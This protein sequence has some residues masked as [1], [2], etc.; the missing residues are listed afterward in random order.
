MSILDDFYQAQK[1]DVKLEV[2]ETDKDTVM[3]TAPRLRTL[4]SGENGCAAVN[5]AGAFKVASGPLTPDHIVYAKSFA[6]VSAV[7][8]A[9][10][11][12]Q[13]G[14]RSHVYQFRHSGNDSIVWNTG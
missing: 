10:V 3:E 1:V 4:L 11:R 2:Q 8:I 7:S 9:Q 12:R 5:T 6:L 14:S 13:R